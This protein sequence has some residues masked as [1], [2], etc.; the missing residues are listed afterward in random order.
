MPYVPSGLVTRAG[1]VSSM[2]LFPFMLATALGKLP[3]IT[4]EV[5]IA[6]QLIQLSKLWLAIIFTLVFIITIVVMLNK[7]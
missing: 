5:L 7:R 1:V 4:L 6:Y 3:S 2:S